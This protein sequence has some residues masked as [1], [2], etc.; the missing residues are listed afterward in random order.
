MKK[1][2]V[3][4][5]ILFAAIL[6]GGCTASQDSNSQGGGTD[7]NTNIDLNKTND[8]N[9]TVVNNLN[10][11]VKAKIGDT[12]SVNYT[13]RFENGDVFDSSEGREPLSFQIGKGS[14][15]SGFENAVIGMK[16]GESKT[17]TLSPAQAYGEIDPNKIVE[18][19]R[20]HFSNIPQLEV[21]MAITFSTGEKGII[22][23]FNDKN[24]TVNLNGEMAGKTLIFDINLLSINKNP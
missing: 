23:K 6:L 7:L 20:N 3:L 1:A 16:A 5:C 9:S 15:I 21:G 19:D 2:G 24:V 11:F 22:E 13:G 8:S 17:V 10:Q 14:L 4:I 18:L 12:V